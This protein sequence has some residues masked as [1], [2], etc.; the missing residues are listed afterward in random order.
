MAIDVTGLIIILLFFYRGYTRGL[1]LA[2]FSVVA[3]LLGILCTLKLSQ[4][5]ASWLL[6]KGYTTM[7]WAPL[8]SYLILFAGVVLAVRLVANLFQKA[9]EGLLLGLVNRIAGGVLYAFL[10]AILFSS[11]LWIGARMN[12]V[13]PKLIAESKTYPWLSLLAPW[14]FS[15]AGYLLPFSKDVFGHLQQFFDAAIKK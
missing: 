13:T 2:V 7:A 1:I 11:L 3:I 9:A 8:L 4:S 15:F 5:L 10:G 12:I 6:M 14:F